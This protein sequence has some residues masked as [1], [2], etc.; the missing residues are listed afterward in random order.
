MLRKKQEEE[1]AEDSFCKRLVNQGEGGGK[2]RGDKRLEKSCLWP[3]GYHSQISSTQ[4]LSLKVFR[5]HFV[6]PTPNGQ[7]SFNLSQTNPN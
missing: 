1:E 7:F 4:V 2:Q 6:K 3:M 5:H